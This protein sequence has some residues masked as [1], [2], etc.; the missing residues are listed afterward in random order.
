MTRL[1]KYRSSSAS[2]QL[3]IFGD[4]FLSQS[5]FRKLYSFIFFCLLPLI[6]LRLL[7][8]SVKQPWYRKHLAE[9][10]GYGFGMHEGCF[11]IH[12]VSVG[13]SK[14]ALLILS[15][16]RRF[17]SE[18]PVVLTCATASARQFLM[19]Q[20]AQD[21]CSFVYYAPFDL[22]C[23]ARR[24]LR[25]L[26]PRVILV[27]E[28][29]LWPNLLWLAAHEEVPVALVNGRMSEQSMRAYLRWP[30]FTAQVLGC[31]TWLGVQ[32]AADQQRF[33]TL[34][35]SPD[36]VSVTGSLKVDAAAGA[37]DSV[38]ASRLK[39]VFAGRP[40]WVA[41]SVHPGEEIEAVI[42]A[43][44]FL[45]ETMPDA[46]LVLVPRHPE[47]TAEIS[48]RIHAQGLR[49]AL[50]STS[51]SASGTDM[52]ASI[53]ILVVDTIGILQSCYQ[54]ADIAFVGGSIARRGGQNILEPL[55]VGVPVITGP[56][57]YNFATLG[58]LLEQEGALLR[59]PDAEMKK[60][61]ELLVAWLKDLFT[62]PEVRKELAARGQAFID[63]QKGS[64]ERTMRQVYTLISVEEFACLK[65]RSV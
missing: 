8:K 27:V 28:T 59:L 18:I 47:K 25:Q 21:S 4:E 33:I 56:H 41:G 13:E 15:Y 23:I 62:Q 60:Q 22:A 19:A 9:R 49:Y 5:M 63:T 12:A 42:L 40:V 52:R 34:G 31:F 10:F 45:L 30:G 24:V 46:L 43:Q 16:L 6:L 54:A 35:A 17:D 14:V 50:F 37:A 3:F 65:H 57:L 39:S 29:E 61:A 7:L 36:K 11:W 55:L 20:L 32:Y 48:K 64:L 2:L 1:S 38:L 51:F 44:R 53:Q 26:N 58:V